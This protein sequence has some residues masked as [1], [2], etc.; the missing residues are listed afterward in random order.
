MFM[1]SF[2]FNLLATICVYMH[3]VIRVLKEVSETGATGRGKALCGYWDI[4]QCAL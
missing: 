2:Y 3:A 1:S 4:I